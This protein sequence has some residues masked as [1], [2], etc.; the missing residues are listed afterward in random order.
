MKKLF[1]IV[2]LS[3]S[4]QIKTL[5]SQPANVGDT[6]M[7]CLDILLKSTEKTVNDFELEKFKTEFLDYC[8]KLSLKRPFYKSDKK[9]LVYVFYK[10]HQK[11]FL[12]FK[13]FAYFSD[14]F[15]N[16]MYNCV[17]AT[18]F[19]ALILKYFEIDFE[20]RETAFHT[21][22]K[23]KPENETILW[24]TTDSFGGIVEDPKEI[25]EREVLYSKSDNLPPK[26]TFNNKVNLKQLIGLQLYNEGVVLFN[27]KQY[28]KSSELLENAYKLYACDRIS[29]LCKLSKNQ[30]GR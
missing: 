18:A 5:R 16:G 11:F 2:L 15:Q 29:E 28:E 21:Y 24:E 10:T 8:Q 25:K 17:T 13:D 23:I 27:K 9:F 30:S 4:M 19:Y 14:V 3:L 26:N 20:I 6:V 1:F 12:K 22:I 7:D